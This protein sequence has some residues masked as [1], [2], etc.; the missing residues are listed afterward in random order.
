MA[1][2]ALHWWTPLFNSWPVTALGLLSLF[3]VHRLTEARDR[4]KAT[5]TALFEIDKLLDTIGTVAR[6]AWTDACQ[7]KRHAAAVETV[8]RIQI[9]AAACQRLKRM[10]SPSLI[11]DYFWP[12]TLIDLGADVKLLRKTITEDPFTIPGHAIDKTKMAEVEGAIAVFRGQ[13]VQAFDAFG[14][15]I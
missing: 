6:S 13:L 8:A 3:A 1:A 9:L 12:F 14:S 7:Y 11:S 2:A 5:S 10:T 4:R 15:T